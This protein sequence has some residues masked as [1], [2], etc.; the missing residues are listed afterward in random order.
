MPT[1]SITRSREVEEMKNLVGY[2]FTGVMYFNSL[3][4]KSKCPTAQLYFFFRRKSQIKGGRV[5]RKLIS[6]SCTSILNKILMGKGYITE[7]A[8]ASGGLR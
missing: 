1:L 5:G 8:N 3:F 6:R 7:A 2:L 4:S